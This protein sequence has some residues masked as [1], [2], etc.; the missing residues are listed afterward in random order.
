VVVA[1]D[2]SG[3]ELSDPG[4]VATIGHVVDLLKATLVVDVM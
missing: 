2:K 1:P 4:L 3:V